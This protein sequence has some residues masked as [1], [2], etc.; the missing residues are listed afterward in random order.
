MSWPTI[1]LRGLQVYCLL[2]ALIATVGGGTF[3]WNGTDGVALVLGTE[4]PALAPMLEEHTESIS[5]SARP[6]FD[7]WYRALGWY[8]FMTGVMLFWIT[9]KVALHSGWFRCI[10]VAFMAVGVASVVT[11]IESGPNEHIRYFGL[12]P[13]FGIPLLAI[14]WQGFV[15]RQAALGKSHITSSDQ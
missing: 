2:S 11:L 7:L 10:H 14:V 1:S 13:E 9:A 4:Y 15:A 3:V 6:S 5:A 12:I 8:W